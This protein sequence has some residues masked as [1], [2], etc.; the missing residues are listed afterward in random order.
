[1]KLKN[2]FLLLLLLLLP[3]ALHLCLGLG[4]LMLRGSDD[5]YEVGSSAPRPSP[6]LQDLDITFSLNHHLWPVQHGRPYQ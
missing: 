5:F 2:M 1:M 6:N 4:F 3:L